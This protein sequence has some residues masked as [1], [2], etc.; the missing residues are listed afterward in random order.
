MP[1]N[2]ASCIALLA[3]LFLTGATEAESQPRSNSTAPVVLE[4]GTRRSASRRAEQDL[5]AAVLKALLGPMLVS[6]NG[7]LFGAGAAGK[8]WQSMMAEQIAEQIAASGRLSLLRA[9]APGGS[10]RQG[11]RPAGNNRNVP[12]QDCPPQ[13]C[14][15]PGGWR[16]SAKR[17]FEDDGR[18]PADKRALTAIRENR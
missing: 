2:V 15:G 4:T 1:N 12:M 8:Q 16:T 18:M 17:S 3:I 11:R 7:G 6:E 5:E 14:T 13:G 10:T 9:A